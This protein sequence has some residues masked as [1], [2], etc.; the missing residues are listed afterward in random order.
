[1]P[2]NFESLIKAVYGKWKKRTQPKDNHLDEEDLAC[3]LDGCLSEAELEPFLHH[4]SVCSDCSEYLSLALKG[5][6]VQVK[7]LPDAL[8][9]KAKEIISL[10]DRPSILEVILRLKESIFEIIKV[11]GDI[12]FGQ[13]LVPAAVLRSRNI[14]GLKDEV[15]ILKD[16]KDITIELKVENKESRYFNVNIQVKHKHRAGSVKDLRVTLIKGGL[17]LESYLSESG[18]VSFEHVALGKYNIEVSS[19]GE[20]LASIVLDMRA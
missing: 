10:K 2:L 19:L 3:L 16:F 20:G 13:E 5:Q 1:M 17:E 15:I 14:K 6:E 7:E 8:L 9:S 4:L 18:S 12:L 11:N